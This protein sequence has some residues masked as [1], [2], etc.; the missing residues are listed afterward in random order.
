MKKIFQIILFSL[1][2][3]LLL[4]QASSTDSLDLNILNA[5]SN[6]VFN[7]MG[8]SPSSIDRPTDLNN[9]KISIQS[10][11]NSFTKFPTDY[12]I[13]FSPSSLLGGKRVS[14]K[15][16][17][18][19]KFRDVAYQSLSIAIGY[20]KSNVENK[21][22]LD[23]TSYSKL[24]FGLKFSI[25]RPRWVKKTEA[26]IDSFYRY[27]SV[28]NLSYRLISNAKRNTNEI[29]EIET[30]LKTASPEK[31]SSLMK[32]L[33]TLKNEINKT[34]N[35]SKALDTLDL[36][37]NM[38]KSYETLRN[39]TKNM[40]FEREGG[41]L[42]FNTGIALDFPDNKFDNSLVSKAGAW[43]TGGYE[44]GNKGIS[45]LGI[46]RYLFQPDKIFA[47]DSSKIKTAN[48]STF[49]FGAKAA[50][51]GLDGKFSFSTEII[52]R[53]VLNANT[54]KPTYRLVFNIEYDLL[55]NQKITFAFGKNFDGTIN[56]SG[57]LIAA[58]NFVRGFGSGKKLH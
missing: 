4:A 45:I 46:T 11:S 16:F 42:D 48:I 49:D 40:K 53:S 30:E 6:T 1:I 21:E 10:A 2:N 38:D 57:N 47:D 58:L 29:K 55:A 27:D 19:S 25:I 41:F 13:E 8:I 12:A 33:D 54:I 18:S 32:K 24:G 17:N 22:T 26:I 15:D 23:S 9:F 7:L 14:L 43:F 37:K 34:I 44:S 35:E 50:F 52:Y 31:I 20:N 39:Y 51:N 36:R 5:P 28:L 3:N 56:K